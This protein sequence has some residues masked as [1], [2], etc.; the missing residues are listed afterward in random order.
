MISISFR[1]PCPDDSESRSRQPTAFRHLVSGRNAVRHILFQDAF[2]KFLR[3]ARQLLRLPQRLVHNVVRNVFGRVASP[4]FGDIKCDDAHRSIELPFGDLPNDVLAVRFNFVGFPVN[5]ARF[6]LVDDK[7]SVKVEVWRNA[8]R[9]ACHGVTST[10]LTTNKRA[11]PASCPICY[12]TEMMPE[13]QLFLVSANRG[14]RGNMQ[15]SDDDY[16][17]REGKP[18]GPLIGRIYKLSVA[19]TGNWWFWAVQL[20]PAVAAEQRNG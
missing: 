19:P 2:D 6:E 1:Q 13:G 5:G 17:V 9:L 3:W 14:R 11:R 18:D 10:Q 15:W 8:W 7:I 16:D 20:F 4:A 12:G